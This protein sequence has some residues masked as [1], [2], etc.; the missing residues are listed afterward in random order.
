MCV[1]AQGV[2]AS[3]Q[4]SSSLGVHKVLNSSSKLESELPLGLLLQQNILCYYFI[5][6]FLP[7]DHTHYQFQESSCGNVLQLTTNAKTASF[8][9]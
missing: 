2:C 3:K 4:S 7:F 9:P 1:R 6:Q 8:I 5:L